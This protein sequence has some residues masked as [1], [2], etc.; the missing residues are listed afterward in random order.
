ML[1]VPST[2]GSNEGSKERIKAG[3]CVLQVLGLLG[4]TGHS[5]Q[6]RGD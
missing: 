3:A 6:G 2:R 5:F 4:I 1:L